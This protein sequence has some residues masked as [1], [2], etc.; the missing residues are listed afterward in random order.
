MAQ[1]AQAPVNDDLKPN[2]AKLAVSHVNI[3]KLRSGGWDEE[4]DAMEA[5]LPVTV[6]NI[7]LLRAQGRMTA[8]TV[9]ERNFHKDGADDE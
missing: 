7:N 4:A 1:R 9:M 6:E 8:A 3:A 2:L 5:K